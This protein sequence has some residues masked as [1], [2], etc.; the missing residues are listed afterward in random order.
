MR[1]YMEKKQPANWWI[2]P[3]KITTI[4]LISTSVLLLL[5]LLC[6]FLI[7][8]TNIPESAESFMMVAIGALASLIMSVLLT[9]FTKSKPIFTA[10]YS[11][12]IMFFIK[13][14]FNIMTSNTVHFGRQGIIGLVFVFVFCLIGSIIGSNMRK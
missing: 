6:S 1:T 5:T 14:L 10:I 11:F 3:L 9:L 2:K 8:K 7:C 13:I 12:L 4:A